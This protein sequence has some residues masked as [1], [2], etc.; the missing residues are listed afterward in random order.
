MRLFLHD[1]ARNKPCGYLAQHPLLDQVI[2]LKKDVEVPK[3]CAAGGQGGGVEKVNCW[4]GPAGS[5]SPLHFDPE[6][7]ILCQVMGHKYIRLYHPDHSEAL[8]PG[9]GHLSN[10]SQLP[11]HL[12]PSLPYSE[13]ELKEGDGLFIPRKHWHYVTARSASFSVNFWFR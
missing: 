4:L 3:Q 5:V 2:E 1:L 12:L 10:T 13:V 11:L 9:E 7:N 6:H 8:S